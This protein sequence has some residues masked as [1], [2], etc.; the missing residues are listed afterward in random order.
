[1]S[2]YSE[3]ICNDERPC[4][5]KV[6]PLVAF[7]Q[8]FSD[9][10]NDLDPFAYIPGYDLIGGDYD[11]S[12]TFLTGINKRPIAGASVSSLQYDEEYYFTSFDQFSSVSNKVANP[13]A[14]SWLV[15]QAATSVPEPST[16]VIFALGMMGLVARRL[17]TQS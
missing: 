3:L 13:V 5:Y 8:L 17:S 9:D 16:L 15:R 2:Q 7:L 12:V 6:N 14:G 4:P 10:Y 1:L 11:S